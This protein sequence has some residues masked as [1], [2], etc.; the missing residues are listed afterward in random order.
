MTAAVAELLLQSDDGAI[1]LLPS[2]PAGWTNGEI[3]GLRARGGYEV[4]LVWDR[5]QLTRGEIK[6]TAGGTCRVRA[7]VPLDVTSSNGM[8]VR[9]THPEQNV[10]Q[11]ETTPGASR[12]LAGS[13]AAFAGEV[14]RISLVDSAAGRMRTARLLPRRQLPN[15]RCQRFL[16]SITSRRM[17]VVPTFSAQCVSGSRC[18]LPPRCKWPR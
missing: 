1:D 7:T 13:G 11:F 4:G 8:P 6:S 17:V 3:R 5:G 10:V 2:L 14:K 16:S 9:A 12:P 15:H 18:A